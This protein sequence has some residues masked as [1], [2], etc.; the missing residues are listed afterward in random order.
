[1]LQRRLAERQQPE[2]HPGRVALRLMRQVGP[3]DDT[4]AD[5]TAISRFWTMAQCSISS[6]GDVEEH[7]AP[8]LDGLELIV[9]ETGVRW[10][11]AG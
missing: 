1:M 10:C 7:S 8:A 9:P 4:G 6:A 11:S 3:A 5:P 2:L